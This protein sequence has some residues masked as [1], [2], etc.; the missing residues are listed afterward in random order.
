MCGNPIH[1]TKLLRKRHKLWTGGISKN[2]LWY[3]L[4]KEIA[5]PG[6]AISFT[7]LSAIFHY[8]LWVIRMADH[9]LILTGPYPYFSTPEIFFGQCT[10]GTW[11]AGKDSERRVKLRHEAHTRDKIAQNED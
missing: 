3:P 2:L 4:C 9:V 7:L 5:T 11:S 1:S 8:F 10:C 6:V